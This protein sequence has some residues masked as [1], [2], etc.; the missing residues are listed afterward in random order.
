M[1]ERVTPEEYAG[2]H[3]IDWLNWLC[4]Y[5]LAAVTGRSPADV[6]RGLPGSGAGVALYF[7]RDSEYAGYSERELYELQ[8][9]AVLGVFEEATNQLAEHGATAD[10]PAGAKGRAASVRERYLGIAERAIKAGGSKLSIGGRSF[11][12]SLVDLPTVG[13]WPFERFALQSGG[14]RVGGAK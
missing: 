2:L 6:F 13:Y 8:Q 11:F 4:V 3:V 1:T 12:V 14:A 5:E 10:R 9:R 7:G